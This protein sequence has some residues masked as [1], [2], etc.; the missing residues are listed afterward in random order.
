MIF[1]Q[2]QV[3][4]W[5]GFWNYWY[6]SYKRPQVVLQIGCGYSI[7][8]CH[9]ADRQWISMALINKSLVCFL[10]TASSLYFPDLCTG[11]LAYAGAFFDF[12]IGK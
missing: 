4:R 7:D 1:Q 8:I 10:A 12:V 5:N 9:C 3:W 6:C 11:A 2:R